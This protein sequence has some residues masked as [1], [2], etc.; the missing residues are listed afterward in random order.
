MKEPLNRTEIIRLLKNLGS[1][2]DVDVLSA[3][4]D[5]NQQ[6]TSSGLDWDELLI[7]EEEQSSHV[8][9][10]HEEKDIIESN[11]KGD[12]NS[13][14]TLIEKI[15]SNPERS[16]AL[17]EELEE[18]KNDISNGDFTDDDHKYVRAL[19]DRLSK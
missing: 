10:N 2:Q 18:Y 16:D 15:L 1:S 7:P 13:S 5:L 19:F 14:L 9:E 8:S 11:V 4:R 12:V 6:I 3:A 17:R